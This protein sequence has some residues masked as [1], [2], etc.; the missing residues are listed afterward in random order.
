MGIPKE[1]AV[2]ITGAMLTI[3]LSEYII[4]LVEPVIPAMHI[5]KT[6]GQLIYVRVMKQFLLSPSLRWIKQ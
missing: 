6:S 1:T 2:V 3:M 4:N 5:M